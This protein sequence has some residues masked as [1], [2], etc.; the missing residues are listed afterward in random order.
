LAD[1]GDQ[2]Y[3]DA[4]THSR[5]GATLIKEYLEE[6]GAGDGVFTAMMN[7]PASQMKVWII[8]PSSKGANDDGERFPGSVYD[9]LFAKCRRMGDRPRID[10]MRSELAEERRNRANGQFPPAEEEE[11]PAEKAAK[12]MTISELREFIVINGGYWKAWSKNRYVMNRLDQLRLEQDRDKI[13][14]MDV[15]EVKEYIHTRYGDDLI[16]PMF[17]KLRRKSRALS[18]GRP[19]GL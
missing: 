16:W 1:L 18:T 12:K 19:Y 17:A 11:I 4:A 14:K 3:E 2:E 7:T 13:D 15:C 9:W 6:M 8:D 5:R 10:C